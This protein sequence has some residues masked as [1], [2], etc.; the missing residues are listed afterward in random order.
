MP[1]VS[2][3]IDDDCLSEFDADDLKSELESRG[4]VVTEQGQPIQG[5]ADLDRIEHLIVCGQVEAAKQELFT[6]IGRA[7]GRQL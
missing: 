2:V 5:L 7:L 1:W 3:H 4:Y 6:T